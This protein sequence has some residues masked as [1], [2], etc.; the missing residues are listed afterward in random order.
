MCHNV[1]VLLNWRAR[2]SWSKNCCL[3]TPSVRIQHCLHHSGCQSGPSK[4]FLWNFFVCSSQE[5][6][7]QRSCST[8][9]YLYSSCVQC[10]EFRLSWSNIF[11]CARKQEKGM[12]EF[13][14]RWHQCY[15]TEE[16][17]VLLWKSL[18]GK[19]NCLLLFRVEWSTALA[20]FPL[21]QLGEKGCG[22]LRFLQ[23]FR[24]KDQ[25]DGKCISFKTVG[26]R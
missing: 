12:A 24:R 3:T 16:T 15:Q 7:F 19:V 4:Y 26:W 18:W 1:V 20:F 11:R 25:A 6:A 10:Q 17:F 22:G 2:Q 8:E 13:G 5:D 21:T 23:A 14:W 9:S